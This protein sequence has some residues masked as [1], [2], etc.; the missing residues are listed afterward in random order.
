M[1][2]TRLSIAFAAMVALAMV[3]GLFVLWA[4]Y[5]AA[6]HAE[7]SLVAT[8]MLNHYLELGANK[9]RLKVWFAESALTGNTLES[10]RDELLEKMAASLTGLQ[11]LVPRDTAATTGVASTELPTL[12][13]LQRN[14]EALQTS[15]KN[16]SFQTI[17]PAAPARV[18]AEK[19]AALTAVFD[20]SDGLDMRP[21]LAQAV[22]R[23][24]VTSEQAEGR[25]AAELARIRVISA[26]LALTSVALGLF[27]V[28]Y[29][30]KRMQ[31]PFENLVRTTHAI[32]EGDYLQQ[33]QP[34]HPYHPN[35]EFDLISQQLQALA[36]RLAVARQQNEHLRQG[37]DDT[38]AAKTADVTRSHEALMRLD[39][40]RRQFF[41]EVSH[42]L[43]TP[44]TVIRGEAEIAL[45][46]SSHS[47]EDYRA[48]LARII[49]AS[50]D[51]ACRVQ[52]LLA[53]AVSEE[54]PYSLQLRPTPVGAVLRAALQQMAAVAENRTIGLSRPDDVISLQL[55][56]AL[57]KAD[58]DRLKQALTIVL[59]NAVRYSDAPGRVDVS[60]RINELQ[61][62]V[63]ITV[64]DQGIGLTGSECQ[65]VFERHFRGQ[66]A[67]NMRPDGA[68]L[69]L[70]IAQAIVVA[71]GGEIAIQNNPATSL[72]GER[73]RGASVTITLPLMA[74]YTP[75]Y[76]LG[77]TPYESELS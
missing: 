30:I 11:A 48:S 65:G 18:Q 43:R 72:D 26:W 28:V 29:F 60:A 57:T 40:R 33:N 38:V 3:Q 14:F 22:V 42:E 1:I 36:D 45:R 9:Q 64:K 32:S 21:V 68:G 12:Q 76:R 55:D 61:T 69:G 58:P 4:T 49:D 75:G 2:R 27:A 50:A 34:R 19:W 5:S 25:L 51:L 74:E 46:G 17:A 47:M 56:N 70:S 63:E 20:R 59:D 31:R 16:S 35:D 54:G 44:V 15:V 66:A 62:S 71:H 73:G 37:L 53:L 8:S 7:R 41:T 39:T 6:K 52:D 67:K 13:L 23:Q 24:R 10:T 77:A